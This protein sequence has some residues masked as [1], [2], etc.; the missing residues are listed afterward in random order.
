MLCLLA[1]SFPITE[2][3]E[4]RQLE[5][6][7]EIILFVS[8]VIIFWCLGLLELSLKINE[9]ENWFVIQYIPNISLLIE[10]IYLMFV[11]IWFLGLTVVTLVMPVVLW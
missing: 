2:L 5:K 4:T 3:I 6:F 11:A 10:Y 7:N 8:T 9:K 1:L